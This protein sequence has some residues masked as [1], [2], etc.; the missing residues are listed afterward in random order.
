[1]I[2]A[3]EMQYGEIE[4]FFYV[5][6]LPAPIFSCLYSLNNLINWEGKQP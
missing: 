1:M 2:F 3:N 6:A 4:G 5:F